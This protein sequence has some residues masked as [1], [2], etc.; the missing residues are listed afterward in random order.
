MGKKLGKKPVDSV[1]VLFSFDSNDHVVF[2]TRAYPFYR[3]GY[4]VT[5][6]NAHRIFKVVKSVPGAFTP[7]EDGWRWARMEC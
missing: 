3:R 4:H 7:F 5:R 1:D 6:K 2:I